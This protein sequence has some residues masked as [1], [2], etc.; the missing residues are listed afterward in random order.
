MILNLL[1]TLMH[2]KRDHHRSHQVSIY[3]MPYPQVKVEYIKNRIIW[4][5]KFMGK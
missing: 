2:L 4:E 1:K 5:V 3:F